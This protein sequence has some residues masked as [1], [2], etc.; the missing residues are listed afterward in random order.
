MYKLSSAA[1][2]PRVSPFLN[3]SSAEDPGRRDRHRQVQIA[4][5]IVECNGLTKAITLAVKGDEVNDR[6]GSVG[7][8]KVTAPRSR[9]NGAISGSFTNRLQSRGP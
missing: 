2:T 5:S 1:P 9:G 8:S 7:D 3:H 4:G 6:P